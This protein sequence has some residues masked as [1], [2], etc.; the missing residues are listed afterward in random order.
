[1]L[2]LPSNP[3]KQRPVRKPSQLGGARFAAAGRGRDSDSGGE[4]ESDDEDA[5][6]QAQRLQLTL[7]GEGGDERRVLARAVLLGDAGA[8]RSVLARR[9]YLA[10]AGEAEGGSEAEGGETAAADRP[11]P[12]A[13]D[14]AAVGGPNDVGE[15]YTATCDAPLH[16]AAR[17]G[18]ADLVELLLA[19]GGT[20]DALNADGAA[21]A[22]VA[23]R[24]G[25]AGAL[26]ML[27]ADGVGTQTDAEDVDGWTALH[28]A[29]DG[30]HAECVQLLLSAGASADP[31]DS[32]ALTPLHRAA[33][34][35]HVA[36]CARILQAEPLC[37]ELHDEQLD[38]PVI[39][40]VRHGHEGVVD[41]FLDAG[42]SVNATDA[43]GT[44]LLQLAAFHGQSK[45]LHHLIVHE[46]SVDTGGTSQSRLLALHLA[47]MGGH[48][49]CVSSLLEAGAAKDAVGGIDQS[50]RGE[51]RTALHYAALGG[52]LETV[53]VLL[54][55]GADAE[56]K[57][58]QRHTV[59]ELAA[60]ESHQH[61]MRALDDHAAGPQLEED[62]IP[63][64]TALS[65]TRQGSIVS[66]RGGRAAARRE[67]K[68]YGNTSLA[69][70]A[71][72]SSKSVS[73]MR[74]R[75]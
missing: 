42:L 69:D 22:H 59:R 18:D 21:P 72:A 26:A 41:A 11:G 12:A 44:S 65:K 15:R 4:S 16:A 46:A 64:L 19:A 50:G 5:D 73:S 47:A 54:D 27:L 14:G 28:H 34:A 66:K 40:A 7:V 30:G 36:A 10:A 17:A 70:E 56:M 9:E 53:G 8:A 43:F 2:R 13:A 35:G 67:G 20:A 63:K 71:A 32:V 29:A 25:N 55:A 31:R 37:M 23:A 24:C 45:M 75:T 38:T 60:L 58:Y 61:I 1:M 39:D 51:R 49:K 6:A 48:T 68:D 62:A 57:D 74:S 52:F 3:A 33:T